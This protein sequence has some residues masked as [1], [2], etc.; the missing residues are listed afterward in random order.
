[1]EK[2]IVFCKIEKQIGKTKILIV[3]VEDYVVYTFSF[4]GDDYWDYIKYTGSNLDWVVHNGV[5]GKTVIDTLMAKA[6]EVLRK[7]NKL[8]N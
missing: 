6:E 1:M 2:S 4:K 5:K 7:L 8:N 3:Q